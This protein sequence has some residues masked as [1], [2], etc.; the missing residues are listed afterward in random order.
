[1]K[2]VK[3][4]Q[5]LKIVSTYDECEKKYSRLAPAPNS[6]RSLNLNDHD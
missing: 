1:M 2:G 3:L 5:K 4:R 6:G